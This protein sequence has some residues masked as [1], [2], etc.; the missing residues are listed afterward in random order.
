MNAQTTQDL[1]SFYRHLVRRLN[2]DFRP[3]GNYAFSTLLAGSLTIFSKF[4][5]QVQ[6]PAKT[7]LKDLSSSLQLHVDNLCGVIETIEERGMDLDQSDTRREVELIIEIMASY[8]SLVRNRPG[9]EQ[10]KLSIAMA[11]IITCALHT[12]TSDN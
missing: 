8:S 4:M 6:E 1:A 9:F 11:H 3:S 7:E 2:D 12:S 10:S 5:E